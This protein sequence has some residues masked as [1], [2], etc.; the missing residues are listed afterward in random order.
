VLQQ[1]PKLKYLAKNDVGESCVA[2]PA[3]AE[4]R[5]YVRTVNTLYCFANTPAPKK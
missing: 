1:G 4:N 3:I 5:I 2:T